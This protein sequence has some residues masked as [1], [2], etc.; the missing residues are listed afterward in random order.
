MVAI[1]RHSRFISDPFGDGGAKRSAQIEELLQRA[2]VD[3]V[4]DSFVLPK[5]MPFFTRLRWLYAGMRLVL[6]DFSCVEIR[7]FGN[8]IRMAKYF[9]LRIPIFENYVESDVAFLNEDTTSGAFGYPYLARSIRKKMIAVPHN[10]ESLCCDGVDPQSGKLRLDWLTEDI[11]RLKM[12]DAVFCISKEETWLLQV[13]GVNAHYL[14][15]YPPKEAES[16]LMGIRARR[17]H[18]KQNETKKFLVLGTAN[19][20]PTRMGMETLLEYFS[21]F[22][23]LPFELHVAGYRTEC[24]E[25]KLHPRFFYHGTLSNQEL[26]NLLVEIDA[27]VINQQASSGALTRIVEHLVAGIPVMASFGAA[28]DYFQEPNVHVFQSMEDLM[29]LLEEYQPVEAKIPE[30]NGN[31][32]H[33]FIEEIRRIPKD[34][35]D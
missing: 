31:A 20:T 30:R 19:N 33:G 16:Y 28:R 21:Q 34:M 11:H 32:E 12:C 18:R 14:P 25:K 22:D 4:N 6:R 15:Y 27:L 8:M 9:G 13:H 29:E 5:G 1:V 2:G 24:L 10:M 26:E 7:S 23:D 17:E 3:Y 35:L